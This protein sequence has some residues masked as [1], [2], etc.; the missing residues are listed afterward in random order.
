MN[1]FALYID[2]SKTKVSI[3]GSIV[4]DIANLFVDIFNSLVV[5][6]IT[7]SINNDAPSIAVGE[8]NTFFKN[9]NGYLRIPEL[10]NLTVDY[11]Y[12]RDPFVSDSDV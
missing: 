2:P 8:V 9:K 10:G 7:K 4:A 3:S 11:A 5:S 6:E 12:T 1:N